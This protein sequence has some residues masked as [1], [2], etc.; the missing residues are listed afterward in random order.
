MIALPETLP[1]C[2][3]WQAPTGNY[4]Q[5]S[6]NH[7]EARHEQAIERQ[8]SGQQ[9]GSIEVGK[10]CQQAISVVVGQQTV[11]QRQWQWQ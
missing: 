5:H 8:G 7:R 11:R 2:I 9:T 3:D 4:S 10:W 1:R 6:T